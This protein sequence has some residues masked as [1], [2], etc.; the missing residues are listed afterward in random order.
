MSL[1]GVF[2]LTG[3]VAVVTGA[4][5]GIGEDCARVLSS[6][7][8]HVV[9]AD[10]DGE[11]AE[12]VAASIEAD[13]GSASGTALDVS[14]KSQVDEVFRA[15][16]AGHGRLDVVCNNAGIMIERPVMEISEQE[17]DTVLAVNLKGVLFGC[18]AAGAL[19][20]RGGSIVN[21]ASAIIDRPS[22]GRASYA[23]S[24]GGV[25]QLTRSFALELGER[26]IRVNAVAPGWVVSGITQRHF[27]DD[28]G[29]PD[30]ARRDAVVAGK[31]AA[32]PLGT[33]GEPRDMALAVLYLA[34]DASRF[35]T[36]Q[37]LRPNGGTVMA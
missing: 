17:F 29:A 2:D 20:G 32:S 22:P 27:I 16:H 8:A 30:A 4:A 18:Q 3:R 1:P 14:D 10:L 21:M 7:G 34:A 26:G 23:A 11:G 24:K 36:G 13:G 33:I 6:A 28:T 35:Y 19:L 5:G 12:K 15:A 9:V 25:V 37:V 31:A